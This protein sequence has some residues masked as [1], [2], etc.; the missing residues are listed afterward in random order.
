M[1]R[2]SKV[3]SHQIPPNNA[4]LTPALAIPPQPQFVPSQAAI[5]AAEI[6]EAPAKITSSSSRP[7]QPAS[8]NA[9]AL[10]LVSAAAITLVATTF[11]F[12]RR[13]YAPPEAKTQS[14]APTASVPAVLA[15]VLVPSVSPPAGSQPAQTIPKS[16]SPALDV[17][18]D[19][20][21]AKTRPMAILRSMMCQSIISRPPTPVTKLGTLLVIAGQDGARVLLDGKPQPQLTQAGRLRLSNLELK[22]YVVQVSKSGFQDPPQQEIR[23]FTKMNTPSLFSAYNR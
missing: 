19:S 21:A 22:D 17:S 4:P 23:I 20:A 3:G 13:H 11:F 15:P 9:T 16:S 1:F 2:F 14:A 5:S 12:T 8:S 18:S 6:S 10:T 7:K